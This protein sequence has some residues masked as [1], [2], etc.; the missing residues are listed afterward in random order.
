[1]NFGDAP[2]TV[3]YIETLGESIG[4]RFPMRPLSGPDAGPT[5]VSYKPAGGGKGLASWG[6]PPAIDTTDTDMTDWRPNDFSALVV[7]GLYEDDMWEQDYQIS[8][9]AA[10]LF[11][12][13]GASIRAAASLT[14]GFGKTYTREWG[15]NDAEAMKESKTLIGLLSQGILLRGGSKFDSF[16]AVGSVFCGFAADQGNQEAEPGWETYGFAAP[17]PYYNETEFVDKPQDGLMLKFDALTGETIETLYDY[18]HW[19]HRIVAGT[20]N[21]VEIGNRIGQNSETV[22]GDGVDADGNVPLA[23]PVG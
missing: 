23:G 20:E 3:K 15:R 8:Q 17:S 21:V 19:H 12:M 6:L 7:Q 1:V 22:D 4:S 11:F 14:A 9:F 18:R 2:G 16:N 5:P 10:P 13:V